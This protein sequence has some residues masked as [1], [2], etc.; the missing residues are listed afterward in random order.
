MSMNCCDALG[1]REG[2]N[3]TATIQER[4]RGRDVAIAT[5]TTLVWMVGLYFVIGIDNIMLIFKRRSVKS[6]NKRLVCEQYTLMCDWATGG[7]RKKRKRGV[8]LRLQTTK[9]RRSVKKEGGKI[10]IMRGSP[11]QYKATPLCHP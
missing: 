2:G 9:D 6:H 3:S 7:E 1:F 4:V 11:H 5:N 10:K 8:T